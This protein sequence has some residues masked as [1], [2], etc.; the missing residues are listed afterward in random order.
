M[1]LQ[2]F[3]LKYGETAFTK[4]AICSHRGTHENFMIITLKYGD[5]VLVA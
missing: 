1:F 3:A 5:M 4:E 2:I